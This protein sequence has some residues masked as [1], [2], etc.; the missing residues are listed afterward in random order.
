MQ[1]R[2]ESLLEDISRVPSLQRLLELISKQ[3][4]LEVLRCVGSL[5]SLTVARLFLTF[6]RPII[7]VFDTQ[8]S[9]LLARDDLEHLLPAE[10]YVFFPLPRVSKW[11]HEDLS[12]I[13]QQADALERLTTGEPLVMLMAH[14]AI[15][16][17]IRSPKDLK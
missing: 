11:G 12:V 3:E 9:A 8:E 4:N 1:N 14:A 17:K 15:W 5:R 2:L 6:R 10:A 16:T 7:W 13:T